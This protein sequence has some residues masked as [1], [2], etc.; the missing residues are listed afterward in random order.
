[1]ARRKRQFNVFSLSFLDIMSCGFGAVIL[2]FMIISAQIAVETDETVR[3]DSA[4]IERLEARVSASGRQLNRLREAL[5]GAIENRASTRAE[6]EELSAAVR[7]AEARMSER[8]RTEIERREE[9]RRLQEELRQLQAETQQLAEE[10]M[11]REEAGRQIRALTG[12]GDR[13]YLTG[14]RMG[15]DRILILVDVSTSMLDETLVNVIRRRNMPFERKVSSDKWQRVL[16]TIDWLTAQIPPTSQFQVYLFN[17]QARPL[18]EGTE[19]TW[20]SASEQV[21]RLDE[22]VEK[23]RTL[24]PGGGSSL[25]AAFGVIRNLAPRADNVYLITDSL[26]TVGDSP[27]TRSVISGRE[28]VRLFELAVRTLPTNVPLN[29]ILF[30][31]EGDPRAAPA[32]WDLTLRTGGTFLSPTKDWP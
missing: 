27:P 13:A 9:L 14:M 1:M 23:T 30:P 18:I 21:G 10:A 17:D 28:R 20:L 19:G 12:D 15:G 29:I 2:F 31:L 8:Q 32:Y 22:A 11:T 25:H 16:A 4:E 3:E 5:A 7:E 24:D 26:P 6:A